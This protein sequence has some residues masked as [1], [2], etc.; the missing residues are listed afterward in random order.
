[1]SNP[2]PPPSRNGLVNQG[3]FWGPIYQNAVRD[4]KII[5]YCVALSN[6]ASC[7]G[8]IKYFEQVY[9]S[10]LLGDTIGKSARRAKKFDLVHQTI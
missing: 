4:W 3:Q 9:C 2:H 7:L 6:F 5:N 10:M 1:M 8:I